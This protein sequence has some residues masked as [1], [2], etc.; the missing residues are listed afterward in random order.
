MTLLDSNVV[1]WYIRPN[2]ATR[3]PALYQFVTELIAQEGF[4]ISFMTMFELRR[5]LEALRLAGKGRRQL[6]NFEKL[7][8]RTEVLGLDA[9]NGEGWNVAARIWA[10]ARARKPALSL[11]D[12]DLIIAATAEFHGRTLA[13]ADMRLAENLRLLGFRSV[14]VV[15]LS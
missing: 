4:V 9:A 13:T 15:P 14:M 6:V 11:S 10:Q 7:L 12:A 1:S 2:C 5:G 3:T 8:E